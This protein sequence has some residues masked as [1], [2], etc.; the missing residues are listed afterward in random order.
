[1]IKIL[2]LLLTCV[3]ALALGALYIPPDEFYIAGVLT[4]GIPFLML[5]TA[6]AL[7]YF[8]IK[9][10]RWVWAPIVVIVFFLVQVQGIFS[11]GLHK[12]DTSDRT[13]VKIISYNVNA[14]NYFGKPGVYMQTLNTFSAWLGKVRPDI[15]CLQETV[16]ANFYKILPSYYRYFSGKETLEGDSLGL[17]IISRYPIALAGKREFAFNSFNRMI[18]TDIVINHDT[19]RVINVHLKSYNFYKA[20]KLRKLKNIKGGLMA[21][22]YHAKL[23][24]EFIEESP[25]KVILCGDLNEPPHSYVYHTLSQ[26]LHNAF[27]DAATGY[28]YTYT[29]MGSPVRIDNIFASKG[30][31]FCDYKTYYD[32]TLSD[33]FPIET[34]IV[35]Q[36][37][38]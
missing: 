26:P 10:S 33:H 22:S 21:R 28:A 5:G 1:M 4:L 35:L 18:W 38:D 31:S 27:E 23:I 2:F 34:S 19:I 14:L 37:P 7:L 24:R 3:S 16:P 15:V 30:I 8:A 6:I 36:D 9:K 25:Y 29:F 20:S 12:E 13:P 11:L 17:F 32:V